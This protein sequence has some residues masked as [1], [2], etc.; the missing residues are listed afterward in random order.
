MRALWQDGPLSVEEVRRRLPKSR[1]S[2]Y[3]TVQTV[4]NRLAERGLVERD[5]K[6]RAIR[7]RPAFSESDQLSMALRENLDGASEQARRAALANLVGDLG[8]EEMEQIEQIAEKLRGNK[9]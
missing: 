1:S 4:L 8:Q 7:Y 3:T 5:T 9:D 2:A 6:L